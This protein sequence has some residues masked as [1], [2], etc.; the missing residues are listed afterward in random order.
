MTGKGWRGSARSL[1]SSCFCRTCRWGIIDA[2]GLF[3]LPLS[4]F[5]HYVS[6]KVL[7]NGRMVNLCFVILSP[8]RGGLW[9]LLITKYV[10]CVTSSH[11]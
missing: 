9:L 6:R 2:H 1:I 4:Y 5:L 8:T 3:F 7:S 11:T 10:Q